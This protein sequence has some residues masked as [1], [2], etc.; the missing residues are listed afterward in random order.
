M[1]QR[2]LAVNFKTP[3][4]AGTLES[5]QSLFPFI[6]LKALH[7]QSPA[8]QTKTNYRTGFCTWWEKGGAGPGLTFLRNGRARR[9][10]V[11]GV[12]SF[13]FLLPFQEEGWSWP[14]SLF[15]F[16]T[17]S[18]HTGIVHLFWK[19]DFLPQKDFGRH[20]RFSSMQSRQELCIHE[21]F[22]A[23]RDKIN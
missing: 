11:G 2:G 1:L 16:S 13:F 9:G 15:F 23:Q 4:V 6:I 18:S 8:T 19:K 20:G 17:F 12:Y 10:G 3:C 14:A 21:I 7:S 5:H 22:E